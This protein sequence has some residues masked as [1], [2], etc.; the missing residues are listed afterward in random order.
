MAFS[1]LFDMMDKDKD[2]ALTFVEFHGLLI[3]L[4]VE[5]KLEQIQKMAVIADRKHNG[6]IEY[7]ELFNQMQNFLYKDKKRKM[8][9]NILKDPMIN[10]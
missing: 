5:L 7:N 6:L 9:L 10:N 2:K 4:G 3:W 1:D 8:A